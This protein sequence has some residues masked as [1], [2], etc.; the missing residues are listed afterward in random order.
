MQIIF[1]VQFAIDILL[2]SAIQQFDICNILISNLILYCYLIYMFGRNFLIL[3][4]S[5]TEHNDTVLDAMQVNVWNV[6]K[7]TKCIL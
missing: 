4:N 1:V 3:P 6:W 5:Y 2:S 7:Y